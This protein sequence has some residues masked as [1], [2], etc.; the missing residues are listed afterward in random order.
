[1]WDTGDIWEFVA[2]WVVFVFKN[3]SNETWTCHKKKWQ[4]NPSNKNTRS[5]ESQRKV[6]TETDRGKWGSVRKSEV[7]GRWDEDDKDDISAAPGSETRGLAA[8]PRK[9]SVRDTKSCKATHWF[10]SS[11]FL[12]FSH[13]RQNSAPE[14]APVAPEAAGPAV[15]SSIDKQLRFVVVK[16]RKTKK[17]MTW[18]SSEFWYEFPYFKFK[19]RSFS[20][21]WTKHKIQ[22]KYFPSVLPHHISH[23]SPK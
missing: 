5:G 8:F 12:Y 14:I 17:L 4:K 2:V 19:L 21:F 1:M 22:K 16:Q 18:K 15:L 11:A 23:S 7:V 10:I 20:V 6:K 13:T 3:R 9:S